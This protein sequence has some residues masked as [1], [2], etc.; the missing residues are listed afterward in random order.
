MLSCLRASGLLFMA[1]EP[2]PR[3][4]SSASHRA[5]TEKLFAPGTAEEMGSMGAQTARENAGVLLV[6][7]KRASCQLTK[8][9]TGAGHRKRDGLAS[10]DQRPAI[11]IIAFS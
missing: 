1:I 3:L 5:K 7:A 4:L 8:L 2:N 11:P 9:A 10:R 6:T